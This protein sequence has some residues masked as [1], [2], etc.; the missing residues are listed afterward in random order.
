[1]S[2]SLKILTVSALLIA[3]MAQF[4]D[5]AR[6]AP[7]GVP[8]AIGKAISSTVEPIYWRGGWGWGAPL[9]GGLIAGA[10][11][12]GALAAPYYAPGYYPG[13]VY[14][15]PAYGPPPG[16]AIAYCMQRFRSYD[17]ASGTYLGYDGYRHPCP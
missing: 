4:S 13:P 11:I 2:T 9:A 1:M 15:V 3:G 5:A 7:I 12:G 8:H 10:L 17:P 6:A 16:N 14:G